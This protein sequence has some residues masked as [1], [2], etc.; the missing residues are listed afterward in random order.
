MLPFWSIIW[1]F[2]LLTQSVANEHRQTWWVDKSCAAR[3]EQAVVVDD[4]MNS[5]IFDSMMAEMMS[6]VRMGYR[7]MSRGE[8]REKEAYV[9]YEKWFKHKPR[10]PQ[11]QEH[12]QDREIWETFGSVS[13]VLARALHQ[14]LYA[15]AQQDA[16]GE[17][18]DRFS[19]SR[20]RP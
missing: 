14:D 10:P 9:A 15:D 3:F 7:R 6:T 5:K 4:S 12:Q 8:D 2:C 13:L 16:C 18:R 11:G 17:G 19:S 1:A 20:R